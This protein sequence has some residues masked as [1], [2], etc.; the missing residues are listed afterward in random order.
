MTSVVDVVDPSTEYVASPCDSEARYFCAKEIP[1]LFV[2]NKLLEVVVSH[3]SES[4]VYIIG[5]EI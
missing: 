2:H 3:G 5:P 4:L 1:G